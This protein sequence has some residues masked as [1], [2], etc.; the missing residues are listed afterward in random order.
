MKK[1][2][3]K[4]IVIGAGSAVHDTDILKQIS[5]SKFNGKIFIADRMLL[6][7]I[8]NGINPEDFDIVT[9]SVEKD[10]KDF[11][12]QFYRYVPSHYRKHYDTLLAC[13]VDEKTV[14]SIIDMGYRIQMYHRKGKQCL[15]TTGSKIEINVCGNV[16]A[17]LISIAVDLFSYNKIALIG[18][19]FVSSKHDNVQWDW[20]VE[21]YLTL[22]MIKNHYFDKKA[23]F[24]N[25]SRNGTLHGKGIKESSLSEFLT[26]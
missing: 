12:K 9:S 6:Q 19:E 20:H 25:L 23:T 4:C 26:Q 8:D 15:T 14:D 21:R 24:Y 13:T 10:V 22:Q 16:G 17:A 11:I 3:S 1:L 7:C 2:S 18:L 5:E